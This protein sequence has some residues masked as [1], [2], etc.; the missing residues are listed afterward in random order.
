MTKL[1]SHPQTF[2]RDD[3]YLRHQKMSIGTEEIARVSTDGTQFIN[4]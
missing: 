4:R 3:K 1:T 2:G